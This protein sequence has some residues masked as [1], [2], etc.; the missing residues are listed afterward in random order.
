MQDYIARMTRNATTLNTAEVA[1]FEQ[2]ADRWWDEDGPLKP[3]H[4][5]NPVRLAYIR[6]MATAHFNLDPANRTPLSGLDVLDIG[7]G[8]GLV[9]EPM[10]RLGARVTGVDAGAANIEAAKAHAQSENL[11]INYE[12]VTA[13]QYAVKNKGRFD[14]VMALEIIE[15]VDN[16]DIFVQNV[17]K[18][19]KPGGLII[20][21]TLNRTPES[22]ALGI[23]AA[24][25]ILRWLPR[26]THDWKKFI[27]PSEFAAH[28]R[29]G[30]AGV[31]DITSFGFNPKTRAFGEEKGPPKVNY[32]ICAT[33][34]K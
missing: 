32:M 17:V 34:S 9:C 19:A 28:L 16:P 3:L 2:I 18:L 29:R 6:R 27:K 33:R 13:E 23:V 7:C 11:S 31:V 10:A 22:F 5:L 26:G 15:H 24:E 21:S 20:A 4:R 8:G 12:A 30:D 1:Q 25:Y 14:I